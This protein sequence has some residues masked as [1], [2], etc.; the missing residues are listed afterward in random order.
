VSHVKQVSQEFPNAEL[1]EGQFTDQHCPLE[2]STVIL[3]QEKA[4][5]CESYLQYLHSEDGEK[6]PLRDA[7]KTSG[8][9]RISVNDVECDVSLEDDNR[10]EWIFTLY[11]FDNSGKVTKEDMSSLM[12]TIYD[13]VDAS[14]NHSCH[15]K[16]KTLRVKLT[17]T[18]EPRSHRRDTGAAF[19]E[20]VHSVINFNC[21]FSERCH[22][23]ENRSADK[24]LSSYLSSKGQSSEPPAAEGQHYC[25]DENTER[26]NHYLDLAGIENYTSRFEGTN[27]DCPAQETQV[28]SSQSQS[29]SRSH[30]PEAQVVHHRRSQVIGESYN[31]A[32]PRA[33]G[34]QFLKSPKGAYKGSGGNNGG[35][36]SNKCH[37]YHPPIQTMLHGGNAAGHGGQDVYHLPHQAPPSAHH[38][39]P[40]QHSHSKRLKARA[41][42]SMSPT[43]TPLTPQPHHQ[44]QPAMPSMLPGM[45]REQ[46]SGPPGS[47]GI[48]VPV[49]PRHV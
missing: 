1:K 45:E 13:V 36:K 2:A 17:V 49:G 22:H 34:A 4:E 43:K 40:L 42:D 35:G 24:R 10:Q 27:P 38:Q 31:P 5:G 30:E 23:D 12:H 37:G 7:T 15:N 20:H 8:K 39:H 33:K 3:P 29:R 26:R 46:A 21:S 41:R 14:V 32:E 25:V 44:Q 28:R 11:D 9:K 16:S 47:P 18:P 48:V 6:E 19:K